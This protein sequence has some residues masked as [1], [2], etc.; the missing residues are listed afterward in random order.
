MEENKLSDYIRI[1]DDVFG[2]K[3]NNI[4]LKLLLE[5]FFPFEESKIFAKNDQQIVD[6]KI[7]ST[8]VFSLGN[9][10]TNSRTICHWANLFSCCFIDYMNLYSREN[11]TFSNCNIKEI[12][13]LKYE[14]DGFYKTH[15][16]SG[17]SSPRTL[18]F[19]YFVNDDYTGGELIF[20]LPKNNEE[21]K[22]HTKKDRLIIWPSNFLYPHKV[23]PV[24][25]GIKFSIVSWA[26]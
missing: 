23:E 10:N 6:K 5:G 17:F 12:Q 2:N 3:K 24:T 20:N 9:L 8:K 18:S 1:Y 15:V 21:I 26:L 16:D 14:I 13:I 25:K 4:L 11:N 22:V 19:I 7:R